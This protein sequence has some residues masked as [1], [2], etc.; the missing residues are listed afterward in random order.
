MSHIGGDMSNG[1]Y[2]R[3]CRCDGCKTAHAAYQ[4]GYRETGR[5]T[6]ISDVRIQQ[7]YARSASAMATMDRFG[8]DYRRFRLATSIEEEATV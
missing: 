7:F 3:G 5:I 4:Q 1:A 6:R 8:I 2:V